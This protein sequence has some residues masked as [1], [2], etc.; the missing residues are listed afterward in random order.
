MIAHAH[1]YI[2]ILGLLLPAYSYTGVDG[3]VHMVRN[4][5]ACRCAASLRPLT[6]LATVISIYTVDSNRWQ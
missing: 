4:S 1:S 2:A 3:P 5:A 6:A